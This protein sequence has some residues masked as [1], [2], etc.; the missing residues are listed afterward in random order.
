MKADGLEYYEYVLLYTDATFVI[1]ENDEYV[2]RENIRKYFDLK[3]E[4]IVSPNIYLG[5]R[6]QKVDLENSVKAREFGYTQYFR[7]VVDNK[8][9]Y[10]N[11]NNTKLPVKADMTMQILY[12][13]EIYLTLELKSED[14]AQYQ[15]LIDI[16]IQMVDLGMINTFLEVSVVLIHL[17]LPQRRHLEQIQHVFSYLK[18]Y[19]NSELV[20]DTSDQVIDQ[21]GFEHQDWISSNFVHIYGKEGIL[22]N[23]P[24]PYGLCF[25]VTTT[26][27]AY[28]TGYTVT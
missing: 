3:E 14:G 19:H 16:Y 23:M 2:L 15:L 17:A 12:I 9:G 26:V 1:I 22:P 20:L 4:S 24:A 25:L 18:K 8:E 10:L 7:V 13:P 27:D 28:R 6:L 5:G 21:S 11:Q